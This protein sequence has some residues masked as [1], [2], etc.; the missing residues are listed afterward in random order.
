MGQSCG[1]AVWLVQALALR[2]TAGEA[3]EGKR[4]EG[5]EGRRP[6]RVTMHTRCTLRIPA[7]PEPPCRCSPDP[8]PPPPAPRQLNGW[9]PLT[10][11]SVWNAGN[12]HMYVL[13]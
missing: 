2:K 5:L 3:K 10:F 11:H 8:A 13:R 12:A 4:G 1:T 9:S 7:S 6:R